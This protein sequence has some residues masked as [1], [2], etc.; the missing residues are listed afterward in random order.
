M[1][2]IAI[3]LTGAL[4]NLLL[5]LMFREAFTDTQERK[6]MFVLVCSTA[7]VLSFLLWIAIL[8]VLIIECF[9]YFNNKKDDEKRTTMLR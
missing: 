4:I 8:I 1:I 7:A 3:Y 9:K 6:R 5:A 2:A